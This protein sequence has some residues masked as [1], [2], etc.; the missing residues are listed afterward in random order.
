MNRIKK[1]ILYI[2]S[3]YPNDTGDTAFIETEIKYLSKAFE[4]IIVLSH[5]DPCKKSVSIPQNVIVLYFHKNSLFIK[6]IA[7]FRVLFEKIFWKELRY[8]ICNKKKLS[9]IKDAIFLLATALLESS[10]IDSLIK[11]YNISICYTFWYHSSTLGCQLT[12]KHM[13]LTSIPVYTRTHRFDLYEFRNTGYYQPYKIQM[14]EKIGKVFFISKN[15]MDYYKNTFATRNADV[16]KL[17]YLGTENFKPF[18]FNKYTETIELLSVSYVVPVKRIHLIIKALSLCAK[19]NI[20]INWTHIGTGSET[21]TII[22]LGQ[23]KLHNTSVSYCFLGAKSNLEVHEYYQNKTVDLFVNMSE[24]EGLPVSIMEA[25]SY[26]TP[27]IAPDVGGINE[28]V[29]ENSGWLLSKDNC[30]EE[31]VKIIKFWNTLSIERKHRKACNAYKKW[32]A[33]FNAKKNY[34]EF[35]KEFNSIIQ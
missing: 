14:D 10:Q 7:C 18:E 2:T 9:C 30:V 31:F 11:K 32:D 1:N 26:G 21:D 12:L 35:I 22:S 3:Q 28:I 29:D 4:N 6:F 23:E 34:T 27:V 15:G 13:G 5:G 24:S 17:H 20:R 19:E 25:M 8:I 16:Y 33:T